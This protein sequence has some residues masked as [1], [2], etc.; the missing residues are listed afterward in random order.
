MLLNRRQQPYAFG[1]LNDEIILLL[2]S[3]GISNTTL[4]AKQQ[5]HL[6]FFASALHDARAAF[7]FLTYMNHYDEAEKLLM[8]SL[9]D[10]QPKLRS[11][12]NTEYSKMINNR[13]EQRCRILV[14]QSRIIFG[15]CDAWGVLKEG[16]CQVRI[17]HDSDGQP[18]TLKGT[19][20]LVTRNPCSHC[21]DL[22]KFRAVE[23]IELAHLVDCIVFSTRGKRPAADLMSG[24]DLDGD[25]CASTTP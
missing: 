13:G 20:V 19:E 8:G 21:G 7:R 25:A 10:L 17:T 22:Q 5:Q 24:G 15:V 11:L 4:L 1:H 6:D 2:H 9:E 14:P 12:I 16:E 18:R 3:L 23:R